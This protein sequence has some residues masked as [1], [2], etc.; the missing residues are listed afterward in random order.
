MRISYY[1]HRIHVHGTSVKFQGLRIL[2]ED[3]LKVH[4]S[5]AGSYAESLAHAFK[6][7]SELS[8]HG[9]RQSL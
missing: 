2:G 1:V 6:W 7:T 5:P 8:V 3:F 4:F 9:L